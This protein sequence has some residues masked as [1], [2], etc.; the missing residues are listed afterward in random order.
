MAAKVT[1]FRELL[2]RNVQTNLA[3]LNRLGGLLRSARASAARPGA[4][5]T[6]DFRGIA[7]EWTQATLDYYATLSDHGMQYLSSLADLAEQALGAT[8]AGGTAGGAQA[9]ARPEIRLQARPGEQASARFQVENPLAEAMN[10][11][12]AA[13]DFVSA[14]GARVAAG[15][16]SFEPSAT[17]I[18]SGATSVVGFSIDTAKGFKA[19][20]IYLST[21]RVVGLAG[22][23][24]G[25]V[26]EVAA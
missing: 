10:V 22:R 12:F 11:S 9:A 21:V 16:L 23:E 4:R 2:D 14:S 18:E 13:E 25:I 1:T 15:C 20:E 26:L 6:V 3:L 5:P 24:I 8:P 19:G 17:T 7:G